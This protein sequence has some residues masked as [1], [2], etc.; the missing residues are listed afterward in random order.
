M[1]S[2]FASSTLSAKIQLDRRQPIRNFL[3]TYVQLS[4]GFAHYVLIM[5]SSI[6]VLIG[7]RE[8]E[9]LIRYHK[10][11][12]ASTMLAVIIQPGSLP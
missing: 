3:G 4:T 2:Q 9:A 1:P 7:R 11:L 6:P 8:S 10:F 5:S 12:K